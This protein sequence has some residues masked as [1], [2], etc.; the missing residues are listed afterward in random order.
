VIVQAISIPFLAVL[1]F[2]PVLWT[3]IA[4]M[5]VRNALMN[6]GNPIFTAFAMEQVTP[7]E[8]A[9]LSAAMTVLWQ[10]GWIVG[11]GWYALLQA[12]LGFDGGYALGFGTIIG[13]YT[14]A[15]ALYWVWFRA[16]DRRVLGQ[17]LPA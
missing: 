5:T 8:R 17:R 6:A 16:V 7:V 4:A 3:V 13:L 2:S 10:V 14:L 11:G 9:T 15:T 1:G 12:T